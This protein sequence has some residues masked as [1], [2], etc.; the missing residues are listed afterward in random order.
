MFGRSPTTSQSQIWNETSQGKVC[1]PCSLLT[2]NSESMTNSCL[3]IIVK[4][5]EK[6]VGRFHFAFRELHRAA[7]T[8]N[9][10]Q[11]GSHSRDDCSLY[12]NLSHLLWISEFKRCLHYF[13]YKYK[14]TRLQ[15]KKIDL[16][17]ASVIITFT[18]QE[19]RISS[20][21]STT[22]SNNQIIGKLR[23]KVML[24]V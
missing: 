1:P 20:M 23:R 14:L 21:S 6:K 19:V 8:N 13:F 5:E 12:L 16:P 22:S 24:Y 2:L 11:T 18:I 3:Q 7:Q 15:L 4:L 9:T 10:T 17:R